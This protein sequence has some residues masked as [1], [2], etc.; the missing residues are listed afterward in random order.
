MDIV[1][2]LFARSTRDPSYRTLYMP[3]ETV[4]T[5]IGFHRSSV[6]LL[7]VSYMYNGSLLVRTYTDGRLRCL[8]LIAAASDRNCPMHT[9]RIRLFLPT[10]S[11]LSPISVQRSVLIGRLR[12]RLQRRVA[13]V[14]PVLISCGAKSQSVH[15]SVLGADPRSLAS[16]W[17]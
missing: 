2:L 1:Q 4:E 8:P 3:S 7:L 16:T 12:P 15:G 9:T 5:I 6:G 14:V 11:T 13:R 10:A 17:R